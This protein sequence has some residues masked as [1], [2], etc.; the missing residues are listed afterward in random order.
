[1]VISEMAY[2]SEYTVRWLWFA[3]NAL[4]ERQ[5]GR[6]SK[7]QLKMLTA[8]LG[9]ARMAKQAVMMAT[10]A[11]DLLN[12]ALH[13][14]TDTMSF[15]EY[16][17]FL[18]KNKFLDTAKLDMGKLEEACW[19]LCNKVF[20][21]RTPKLPSMTT[22]VVYKLWRLFYYHSEP[23]SLPPYM[24]KEE[25]AYL[26]EK[27]IVAM[28][29]K[30]QREQFE[31]VSQT[32]P[33]EISM[34][35][36][37]KLLEMKYLPDMDAMCVS[38]GISSVHRSLVEEVEKVGYLKKKGH[39]FT[40]WKERY[41][42]LKLGSMS[43]FVSSD[44]KDQKGEIDLKGAWKVETLPDMKG[45]KNLFVLFKEGEEEEESKEKVRYELQAP[46][47]L[48]RQEWITALQYMIKRTNGTEESDLW[49]EFHRRHQMRLEKKKMDEEAERK[50]REDEEEK[51]RQRKAMEDLQKAHEE[52]EKKAKEE[53]ELR[54][55]KEAEDE[56]NR[57]R[58]QEH[59]EKTQK[60][61][62]KLMAANEEARRLAREE[63]EKREQREL[64]EQERR[65]QEEEEKEKMMRE[66]AEL[67]AALQDAEKKAELEAAVAELNKQRQLE[68]E[69]SLQQLEGLLEEEKQAKRDEEI[70]RGLQARLLEEEME[71]REEL[72]K[73]KEEQDRMLQ[74][75]QEKR[76]R[77]EQVSEELKNERLEQQRLLEEERKRLDQLEKDRKS[78]DEQLK[79][80]MDK[81]IA[82]EQK[83]RDEERRRKE[84]EKPVGL[85][86][87]IQPKAN[88]LKTHRG[89][90]A[91]TESQFD[92]IKELRKQWKERNLLTSPEDGTDKS[93]S[94]S[95]NAISPSSHLPAN[96]EEIAKTNGQMEVEIN[97]EDRVVNGDEHDNGPEERSGEDI[98]DQD[99]S[100]ADAESETTSV[101]ANLPI[102]GQV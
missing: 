8:H 10:S 50:Q 14:N 95:G 31:Q 55:A 6:L 99:N 23:N 49:K 63:A 52:A 88:P 25:A 94:L 37:L 64:E 100:S 59:R 91:F 86:R 48:V 20:L 36:Y 9:S 51:E 92:I 17:A 2:R 34:L 78:A 56:L 83:K 85:A 4:D 67:Q 70:V 38:E 24:V 74:E 76:V 13:D 43:Y 44:L 21:S 81:L 18:T 71:K 87:L 26:T 19:M 58:E 98:V 1:M 27:L 40:N 42:I 3:F 84:L 60:E 5:C 30:F 93:S 62:E 22:K 97:N 57:I 75:E 82:A 33:E 69:E 79:E 80:A 11:T 7:T 35:E 65:R 73:L 16:V 47:P 32:L 90:G 41:F 72:E 102:A 39:N 12:D 61:I 28:G 66:F 15:D 46:D 45:L 53:A 29:T 89:L 101:E 54:K 77:L 68:L 96:Q